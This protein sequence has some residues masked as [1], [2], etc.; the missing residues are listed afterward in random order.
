MINFQN[1]KRSIKNILFFL[2][3]KNSNKQTTY[4]KTHYELKFLPFRCYSYKNLEVD[5]RHRA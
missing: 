1:V 5:P 4:I 2:M 3:K